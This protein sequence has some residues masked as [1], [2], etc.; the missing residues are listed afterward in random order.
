MAN[1]IKASVVQAATAAYSLP[2]T[3]DKLEKFTRL[4]KERDGAQLVVFPEAFIGGYP[5]MSTFGMVVGDRRPEGRD[6]FVRYAKAAIEIP[7]PAIATIEQISRDTNVFL[8]VGVIERDN[9]T[10][11]C[12][13]VF[14]D[15]EKGY[16]A[17][18]RKLVPTAMERTIWGQGDGTTLPVLSKTFESSTGQAQTKLSA[19]ICWENYMPLLRTWYYSQGTQIYCA[20]TVDARPLWQNTMTHIALEGRCF[21]LSACQFSQ[22]KDYPP[23]HA[24]ADAEARNPENVMIAGGSVIISPLGKVLAGPLRDGEGVISAELDLDDIFRGKF[25]LDT[26]GHYARND[27]FQLKLVDPAVTSGKQ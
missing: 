23:D 2:E 12:T 25:D 6:E 17:K 9:G 7:S 13:A 11:Y 22:E 1:T 18:H 27:V 15:P 10:L 20:P 4:A 24:V 26:T 16:V 8:V 3:L 19:T 5:K 21:V 14:V